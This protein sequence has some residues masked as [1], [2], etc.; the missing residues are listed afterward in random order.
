VKS[1][2]T[3]F[4]DALQDPDAVLEIT[5][6]EDRNGELD[7]RIVTDAVHRVQTAGLTKRVFLRRALI[8]L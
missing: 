7:V 5:Y 6:V 4:A 3:Y 8:K 1:L 2:Q